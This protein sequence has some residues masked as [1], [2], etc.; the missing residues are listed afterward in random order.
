MKAD[1]KTTCLPLIT[2]INRHTVIIVSIPLQK[3]AAVDFQVLGFSSLVTPLAASS[4]SNVHQYK[5]AQT[6]VQLRE[7]CAA[8]STSLVFKQCVYG[9]IL[10]RGINKS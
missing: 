4:F 9:V 3:V 6:V 5:S 7:Y 8:F 10:N 2:H 1:H